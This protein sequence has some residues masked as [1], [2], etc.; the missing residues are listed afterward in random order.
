M[1]KGGG[2]II[3]RLIAGIAVLVALLLFAPPAS[4]HGQA[5]GPSV[6]RASLVRSTGLVGSAG[7]VQSMST[8]SENMPG[9]GCSGGMSC[10]VL[11]QCSM[12]TIA[13]PVASGAGYRPR[14]VAAAYAGLVRALT[15]GLRAGPATPPPRLNV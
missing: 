12:A 6:D 5:T 1:P 7:L 4:A 2:H 13:F 9:G 3:G 8:Q 15:V 10:C 11:G 14:P